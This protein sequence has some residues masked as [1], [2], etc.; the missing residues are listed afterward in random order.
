MVSGFG[1]SCPSYVVRGAGTMPCGWLVDGERV[2]DAGRHPS[3]VR[4]AQSL[5]DEH[6]V[7]AVPHQPVEPAHV[8]RKRKRQR[9]CR[10]ETEGE[11]ESRQIH[12]SHSRRALLHEMRT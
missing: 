12:E 11:A 3:V 10:Y 6:R 7:D 9:D 5:F 1:S 4:F 2:G 8:E